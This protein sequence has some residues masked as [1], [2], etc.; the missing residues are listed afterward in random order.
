MTAVEVLQLIKNNLTPLINGI[1][2][3]GGDPLMQ[4]EV[5]TDVL[6]LIKKYY[7]GI[8]IWVYTGYTFEEVRHLP[9]LRYIDVLVDGPY[10]QEQRNISLAFRGSA[11]QRLIDVPK[12][13]I[14]DA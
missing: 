12:S 4:A 1:T 14:G 13:L 3:S 11:N 6:K 8:N 5:L 9:A 10:K 7:P 2:F